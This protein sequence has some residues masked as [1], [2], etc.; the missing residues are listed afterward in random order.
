MLDPEEIA[1]QLSSYL[2]ASVARVSV[3]ASGWETTVFAFTLESR[4]SVCARI[5]VAQPVVLRFYEGS[6]A[7]SKGVREH[8]TIDRL[9]SAGFPVP[10]PYLFEPSHR[11]LGAP[12]LIMQRL[13]GTPLFGA[14]SFP[15][16]F[17][18]FSLG[19]FSFVLAQARLHKYDP[20]SA[21]LREIPHAFTAGAQ[22][23]DDEPPLLDRLLKIIA[24]R[25]E[26]GPLPGLREALDR[27]TVR[28]ARFRS[29]AQSIVHM[30]YHPLNVMVDGVCVTGVI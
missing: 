25:V 24:N 23:P 26:N 28:A 1:R 17:K 5:P 18:T 4:S 11:A 3:L 15:T 22:S 30:D 6:A 20:N 9:S 16:A 27:L 2:D 8:L 21:G 14:R 12:F 10:R 7:D 13:R 29:S 19:F